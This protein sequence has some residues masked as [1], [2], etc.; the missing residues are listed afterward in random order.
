MR[1]ATFLPQRPLLW[2]ALALVVVAC[3]GGGGGSPTEP[4]PP[5]PPPPTGSVTTVNVID[6]EFDP[7]SVT[8]EPGETVRWVLQGNMT[9][10]TT[11]EQN[12]RWDSGFVFTSLGAS[13]ERTFPANENG[14]TFLYDCVTHRAVGMQGSVRVGSAAPPPPPG[15]E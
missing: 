7:R 8:V 6:N 1:V 3:G 10:H 11:T 9:N 5:P 12:G 4:P 13:F 15:Y 14:Q 2:T